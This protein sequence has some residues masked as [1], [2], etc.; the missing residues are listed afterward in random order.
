[1]AGQVVEPFTDAGMSLVPVFLSQTEVSEYYRDFSNRTL[2]PLYHDAVR[3]PE[4]HR[5]WW[6]TYVSV[7]RRFAEAAAEA[8]APNG[9]AWVHDYHLQLVPR[10]LR[11]LRPDATISFF[12]H[13]PFP[14]QELF[15]QLPWRRQILDG[16][17]GA[18]RVG[19]QT[20]IGAENFT[21]LARRFAGAKGEGARF[22]HEGT[23]VRV[24]ANPISI[25]T[26]IYQDTADDPRVRR[27]ARL[28]REELGERKVILGVD[29][30]D[31]TK[32]IDVRLR[33]Y[34]ALLDRRPE[35]AREAVL[36]QVA[37]PNREK[38]EDYADIRHQVEQLVGEINGRYGEPGRVPVHYLYRNLPLDRLVANYLAAD[39]MLVTPLRDGMNLVA[40]E[41]VTCRTDETGVL[42]LSEFTGAAN[43]LTEALLVNPHDLDGVANALDLALRF[44]EGETRRRM[45]ALRRTVLA[46][47]VHAWARRCLG[48][49]GRCPGPLSEVL[50]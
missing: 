36:V 1:V 24:E 3:P 19:F 48:Q 8:L 2:W 5:H 50:A 35:L 46:N 23:R 16:L 4:Y 18:D 27:R 45:R 15:S 38:V 30:L 7:N 12:L 49:G 43:E 31:Y 6:R 21:A 25:D 33:A 39:V 40:K 20:Q 14:P 42:I 26:K 11:E 22:E 28:L 47:D 34:A 32:G 17:L 37:V 29:R 9:T 44:P 10:M 41:Y 13:I